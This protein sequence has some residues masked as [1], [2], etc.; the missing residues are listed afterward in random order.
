MSRHR[1]TVSVTELFWPIRWTSF[2]EAYLRDDRFSQLNEVAEIAFHLMPFTPSE[3]Q[4]W[5]G[6]TLHLAIAPCLVHLSPL[7]FQRSP[8]ERAVLVKS[9]AAAYRKCKDGI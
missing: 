4:Q 1:R 3:V 5:A 9:I 8:T 7:E 6:E 2:I